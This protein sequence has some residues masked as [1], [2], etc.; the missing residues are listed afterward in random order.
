MRQPAAGNL[1]ALVSHARSVP[2]PA[3]EQLAIRIRNELAGRALV[4]ETCHRVEAYWTVPVEQG[5]DVVDAG[6]PE[7]VLV[8]G[9]RSVVEHAVAVAV[10]RDSVVVGED[11]VLH[12][13]RESVEAARTAGHL[14]PALERLFAMALQAGRRARSWR[15]GPQRSLAD[16]AL[17]EIERQAGPLRGRGVLVVGAGRMGRLAVT[18]ARNAGAHVSLTSHTEARAQAL[19]SSTGATSAPFDPGDLVTGFAGVI[20]ALNGPWTIGAQTIAG[21]REGDTTVVDISVP[22]AVP[23]HLSAILGPRLVSADALA[24][25]ELNEPGPTDEW[26]LR[27]DLLVARTSGDYLDWL[28][29]HDG[30]TTANALILSA[31]REREAELA[32]LWRHLPDLQPE[33]RAAID[34]MTRHLAQRLLRGPLEHLGRDADGHAGEVVRDIFAL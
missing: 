2:A 16:V 30:R 18:A 10:G 6:L 9:G 20:V 7:G 21:L 5:F 17:S 28:A 19:A 29:G 3:R 34:E 11:Q 4:L 31:E 32:R 24:R 26:L 27:L 25:S 23:D 12:Q 15:Q 14:D 1:V 13:L 33:A 22:A 8:L